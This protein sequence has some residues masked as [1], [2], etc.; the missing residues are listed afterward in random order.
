MIYVKIL[1]PTHWGQKKSQYEELQKMG[2]PWGIY[3]VRNGLV[4]GEGQKEICY[5]DYRDLFEEL[6][7]YNGQVNFKMKN[8]LG[9]N[10]IINLDLYRVTDGFLIAHSIYAQLIQEVEIP[11]EEGG[12]TL[13]LCKDNEFYFQV[14]IS[15]K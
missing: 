14:R 11:E 4:T 1:P 10:Q 15:S 7:S 5:W 6:K 2:F 13:L 9:E 8:N 3:A 12:G